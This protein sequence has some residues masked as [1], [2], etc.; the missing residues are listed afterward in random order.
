MAKIVLGVG[1]TH[2]P[3]LATPPEAWDGRA[4]VD[5]ANPE[6]AFRDG[7]YTFPELYEL[8]KDPFFVEQNKLAVRTERY[9]RC[10]VALDTLGEVFKKVAPDIIDIVGD[11][12]EE[13]FQKEVQPSFA[14][15]CGA[16]TMNYAFTDEEMEN[17]RSK[18]LAHA[19]LQYHPEG[20]DVRYDVPAE[21]AR[22]MVQT[23]NDSEI[24]VAFL[25]EQP[26]GKDGPR[27]LGHAYGYVAMR[28]LKDRVPPIVPV[29]ANTYYPPNQPTPKRCYK[30]GQ[31][32]G[33][34]IAS[35]DKDLRVA[36]CASGGMSHFV[37]DEEFDH[38]MI[39][40]MKERDEKT[41][42]N[43]PNIMFRSGTSEIKNWIITAGVLATTDAEMKVL[44][45]V[46]CYRSEAGTGSGMAFAV[47]Q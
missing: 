40:A 47:W 11:D 15:Y 35:W 22:H 10:Q 18:G 9:N 41:I 19:M 16:T 43:E 20:K 21:L 30:F 1:T 37:V 34:A 2:G 31:A 39:N 27:N 24:D 6:L 3:L 12:Q 33:R 46:P 29:L 14:V 25:G 23:S 4:A 8:R 13:W 45:Y 17:Y 7:T 26:Q 32:L 38:R 44:D 42:F 5:R 28:I 36:V